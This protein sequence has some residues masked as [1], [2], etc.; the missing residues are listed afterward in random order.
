MTLGLANLNSELRCAIA[1]ESCRADFS[2]HF[3]VPSLM[4][5]LAKRYHIQE[6]IGEGTKELTNEGYE[7]RVQ[8][9]LANQSL[10]TGSG[11]QRGPRRGFRSGPRRVPKSWARS[12][13]PSLALRKEF[14]SSIPSLG[15][16]S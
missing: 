14:P 4:I 15:G 11:P 6:G 1:T 16:D 2:Y 10:R 13:I 9:L 3:S 12:L 7:D 5:S 8:G